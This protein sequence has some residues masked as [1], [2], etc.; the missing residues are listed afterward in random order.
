MRKTSRN[1]GIDLLR[2][3]CMLGVVCLH[4]LSHGGLLDGA[5]SHAQHSI[6]WFLE[7]FALPAVNCFVLISG[8]CG[9]RES[10]YYPKLKNLISITISAL[11]YSIGICLLFMLLYPSEGALKKLFVA[12]VPFRGYWFFAAYFGMFLL[13]PVLNLFVHKG[14]RKMHFLF[15]LALTLFCCV[16]LVLDAFTLSRGY[17]VFWL[18]LLYVLGA[19]IKKYNL[20]EKLSKKAWLLLILGAFLIT[21]LPIAILPLTK[22][23]LLAKKSDLFATYISPTTV[24]MAIGW[25]CFCAKT[26]CKKPIISITTFITPSVFSVYLIHDNPHIRLNWFSQLHTLCEGFST[27]LL[28]LFVLGCALAIFLA[29][30]LID[31]VRVLLFRLIRLDS[32]EYK[33][34]D[35]TKKVINSLYNKWIH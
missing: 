28:V 3:F 4:L 20:P 27:S 21:W 32:A 25:L 35:L 5:K 33:L 16:S 6:L 24:L 11:F 12:C 23:S 22:I 17:S 8:F 1:Y 14:D 2:I 18:V 9:Y 13:M 19:I 34:A 7:A 30:V 31:K 10:C 15:L 29:C 26:S